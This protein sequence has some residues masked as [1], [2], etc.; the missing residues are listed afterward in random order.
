MPADTPPT[1]LIPWPDVA[2]PEA[3]SWVEWDGSGEPPD[4]RAVELYVVPYGGPARTLEVI[5]DLPALRA[6]QVLTAGVDAVLPHLP[7]G[8]DLHSGRGLHDASTAEHAVGLMLAAQRDLPRWVRDQAAGR[9]QPHYTRSLA[10]SRV[11][12]VGF[13]S[14]GEALAA[15][16]R[17]F[18]VEVVP[19]ARRARPA[20]GVLGIEALDDELPRA[21]VV[22]LLTPLTEATRGLLDRRRLAR[23]PDGALVV[24]VARGPVLDTQALLAEQ[25]RIRAALDVTDPEPLPLDHPLWRA[26]GALVTPHVAGGSATFYPR[27][28]RFLA[29][30]LHRWATGEP[31]LNRV[32]R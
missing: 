14:I 19:L 11:L 28:K 32:D 18:E 26:P 21:D 6:V 23:L 4:V 22:V 24:N 1:V 13:G 29:E 2:I 16:L 7:D 8:V 3:V 17:P 31:M 12:I 27:A 10:G 25:G 5:A 9:W 15:R 20:Q 30:Q